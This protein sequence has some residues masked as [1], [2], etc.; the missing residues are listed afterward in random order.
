MRSLWRFDDYKN[1][2]LLPTTLLYIRN[3][4]SDILGLKFMVSHQFTSTFFKLQTFVLHIILNRLITMVLSGFYYVFILTNKCL[5]S[6]KGFF[7]QVN[8][9]YYWLKC[10]IWEWIWILFHFIRLL[11][12][13][14][15]CLWGSNWGT[16][17]FESSKGWG[18]EYQVP[19]RA[20]LQMVEL[21]WTPL[22]FQSTQGLIPFNSQFSSSL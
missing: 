8:F 2:L 7:S 14:V 12:K 4:F 15:T 9:R 22:V 5:S 17:G 11:L 1:A 10:W 21:N 18:N 20:K 13:K 16:N 6:T 3:S 19:P